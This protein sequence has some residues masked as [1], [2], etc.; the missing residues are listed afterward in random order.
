MNEPFGILERILEGKTNA[1]DRY[2][3]FISSIRL[4]RSGAYKFSGSVNI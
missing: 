1:S 2:Q 4:A 3:Q